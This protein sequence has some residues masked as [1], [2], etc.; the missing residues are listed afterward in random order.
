MQRDLHV[1]FYIILQLIIEIANTFSFISL[2]RK[3]E[4]QKGKSFYQVDAIKKKQI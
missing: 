2:T 3:N 1:L 4:M